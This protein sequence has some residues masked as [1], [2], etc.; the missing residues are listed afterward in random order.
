MCR[1]APLHLPAPH[2]ITD[3]GDEDP[4]PLESDASDSGDTFQLD[5]DDSS[6][7]SDLDKMDVDAGDA[8]KGKRKNNNNKNGKKPMSIALPKKPDLVGKRK[9][10]TITEP[11][12]T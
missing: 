5:E 2:L 9:Q 7:E 8:E 12:Q 6:E 11:T 4:I 1:R 3:L 10:D